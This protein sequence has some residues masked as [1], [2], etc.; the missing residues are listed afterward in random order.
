M[1][2]MFLTKSCPSGGFG[3]LLKLE[4]VRVLTLSPSLSLFCPC[5]VAFQENKLLGGKKPLRWSGWQSHRNDVDGCRA[6]FLPNFFFE[7]TVK[8]CENNIRVF[9]Q[10]ELCPALRRGMIWPDTS[11]HLCYLSAF[12]FTRAV[13][14]TYKLYLILKKRQPGPVQ[15]CSEHS[16][17]IPFCGWTSKD[18]FPGGFVG[19]PSPRLFSS[20]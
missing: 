3:S 11:N 19:L 13:Q 14:A 17:L 6:F 20:N 1:Y 9:R 7:W 4:K 5:P 8:I 10:N 18:G 15:F 2:A 16:L 12:W